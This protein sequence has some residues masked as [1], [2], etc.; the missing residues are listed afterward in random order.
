VCL[1]IRY[2]IPS[3]KRINQEFND[4]ES[5]EYAINNLVIAAK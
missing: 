3:A 2:D 1:D 5:K 4:S